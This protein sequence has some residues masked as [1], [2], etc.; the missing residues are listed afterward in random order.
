MGKSNLILVC[1]CLA[2]GVQ[3]QILEFEKWL[4]IPVEE[5]PNLVDQTF[6]KQPLAYKEWIKAHISFL[7]DINEQKLQQYGAQWDSRV[8]MHK[9]KEIPFYYQLFG[10]PG[11]AGYPLFIS[12]HGGGEGPKE[13][14]DQQYENQKHLYDKTLDSLRGMYLA[15][16]SPADVWNMWH[17]CEVDSLMNIIIQ[18]A[19]LKEHV[20]RDGI[21]LMGYSAGGDG[22]YQLATRMADRWTAAAMMAGYPNETSYLNLRNIPFTIHMGALDSAYNRNKIAEEWGVNLDKAQQKDPGGY[23]HQVQLHEG[24]GHWM[25]GQDSAAIPWLL[26]QTRNALPNKIVWKQDDC[27]SESF[28]WLGTPLHSAETGGLI[29]AEFIE[30]ERAINILSNYSDTLILNLMDGMFLLDKEVEIRY[31]GNTIY[32]GMVERNIYNTYTSLNYKGDPFLSYPAKLIVVNNQKVI[33][34]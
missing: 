11:D 6:A 17:L 19:Q 20:D 31:Q 12:M 4:S 26:E 8:L 16:R 13:I 14:N 29:V 27:H 21:Y 24:K 15:L 2:F 22:V 30:E 7:R 23:I 33:Q 1:L 25:D 32:K 28:Y 10:E 18:M 9:G 3:G 5:R 34:P